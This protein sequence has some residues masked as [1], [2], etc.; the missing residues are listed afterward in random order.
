[1]FDLLGGVFGFELSDDE[2]LF[3]RLEL[4]ALLG[5]I[6]FAS[7]DPTIKLQETGKA[8]AWM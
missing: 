8:Q 2:L 3:D 4:H 7:F 1:M 6:G 5:S